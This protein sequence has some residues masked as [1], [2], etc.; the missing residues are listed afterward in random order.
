MPV[1]SVRIPQMGE[2]LQEARLV[3]FLKN[4]GENVRR[5]DPLYQMETDKAV[6]DVESP[7]DGVLMEWTA[8]E[9]KVLPIGTEIAKMEVADGV[10]E[11][12]AGHGP[13]PKQEPVA[14]PVAAAEPIDAPE[15]PMRNAQVPPRVRRMLKEQGLLDEA[16][17]IPAAGSKLMPEDVDR[18]V[19]A[20]SG[21]VAVATPTLKTEPPKTLKATAEYDEFELA[22]RQQTLAYRLAR[23]SQLCVPGTIM[24]RCRW[25]AIEAAREGVKAGSGEFQ[26]SAFTMMSWC[27][28]RAMADHPKFRST[29][30]NETTLRT[31]KGANLGIAVALPGDELV[32]ALVPN[33]DTLSWPDFAQASRAQI[34]KAR[35]GN[36]QATEATTLSIT[37][38]SAFG[39]HDAVPV[40]VSPSVAT[41]F[42]GEA[43]WHPV[44]KM[45]G[46][47]FVRM[48]NLSLTFDHRVINGVG[49]ANF[50]NAV[51][52]SI[53][54]FTSPE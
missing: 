48:V 51:K 50:I 52:R 15:G 25:D 39:L 16:H 46:Y 7:Y 47:D 5:D 34:E 36:D 45:G 21:A 8:E 37:N 41:L 3:G 53:E 42:L 27:V 26:P 9:G 18:Y 23:G 49:A 22:K 12:A 10:R 1:V 17:L 29:M 31:Y 30:P 14:Q 6:M 33:A 38:M 54:S 11:M 20:R 13:A 44:A 19:A 4:P 2:G 43:Y 32:T 35:D 24:V 28:V 40:V